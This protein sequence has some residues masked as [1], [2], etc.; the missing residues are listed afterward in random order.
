[1]VHCS[2]ALLLFLSGLC[3]CFV[4]WCSCVCALWCDVGVMLSGPFCTLLT[5]V[6][7][8]G[9]VLTPVLMSLCVTLVSVL[10]KGSM[11]LQTCW[12]VGVLL[13]AQWACWF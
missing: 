7:Q 3:V 11:R 6:Q 12:P 4:C 5:A 9:C 2:F 13:P 1:L 10:I 8:V